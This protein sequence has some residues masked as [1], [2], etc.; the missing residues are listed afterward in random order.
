MS[1]FV[2][3]MMGRAFIEPPPFDLPLSYATSKNATPLV[4]VLSVG[5]DPMKVLQLFA[6]DQVIGLLGIY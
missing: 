3:S 6:E 2:E 4:F 1:H 5:T